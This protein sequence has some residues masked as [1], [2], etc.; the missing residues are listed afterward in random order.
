MRGYGRAVNRILLLVLGLNAAVA[1]AKVV[2]GWRIGSLSLLGDG[3]HSGVDAANNVVALVVVYYASRPADEDHPYGHGKFETLGA[4]V[5]AGLLFITAFEIAQ[6][7]V[8]RLGAPTPLALDLPTLAVLGLTLAV[9][10]GV[11]LYEGRAGR[12]LG[13]DILL[14]DAA[15]TRSDVWVTLAV[16]AGF[17]AT[18]AGYPRADPA[19]ALLVAGVIA[20][21]G[22]RVFRQAA[23]VLTDQT[24]FDPVVVD[25]LVRAVDGV[26]SVHDIRSRGR[27][28]EAYVQMHLVVQTNDVVE[29]HRI[30]DDVERR[31]ERDLGAKEVFIHVEPEDDGSG[32]PGTRA[33]TRASEG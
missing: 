27:P 29:A 22:Y 3:A 11:T 15:H 10:L 25:R 33:R 8:R 5:L 24:V 4:F 6:A 7:A 13:S 19:I 20:F 18:H 17:A 16:L 31:L 26:E 9:N 32:P 14:A 30:A 21:S 12:R 23:P 1:L 2:A 28:G